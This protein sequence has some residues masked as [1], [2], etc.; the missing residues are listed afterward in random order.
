MG[1]CCECSEVGISDEM[2][3]NY[4][5]DLAAHNYC[6]HDCD[7]GAKTINEEEVVELGKRF[8][9]WICNDCLE[10]QYY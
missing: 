1:E 2:V 5:N 10:E 8:Y 3:F 7:C 4:D 6:A 9:K